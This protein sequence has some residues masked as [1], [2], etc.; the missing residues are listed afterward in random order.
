M[1]VRPRVARV[2]SSRYV[3]ATLDWWPRDKCDYK[4]CPWRGASMLEANLDD[5]LL[6]SAAR[7]L[8]PFY[9]RLGATISR[10]YLPNI[11]RISPPYLPYISPPSTCD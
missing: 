7:L 2:V 4:R 5:P 8:A 3:C 10:L 11:S 1:A 9:L 6:R